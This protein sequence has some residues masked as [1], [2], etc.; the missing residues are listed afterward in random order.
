MNTHKPDMLS[1]EE[2]LERI[3]SH[4][5]VLE[6]EERPILSALG[7][8]LAEDV[9]STFAIP[10]WANSAMDGY[11][12]R[13]EDV[14]DAGPARPLVLKVIGQVAA[15]QLPRK[16]VDPGTAIRIMTGAPIPAGADTVV[17]FE[18][19][20]EVQRK[21]SGADLSRI[22]IL[23]AGKNGGNVRPAGEDITLGEKVLAQGTVLRPPEIGVLASLGKATVRVVRRPVVAILATGDELLYPGKPPR[24][25]KIYDGNSFS[26]AA[27]V[28]RYGGVAKVLGIARDNLE[29]LVA[30]VKRGLEADLLITSAGVSKGDYDIVKEVLASHGDVDFWSVRMKPAKPLAFGVLY[31]ESDKRVPLMGLPGNPVSA[32]VALEVLGRPAIFKLLGRSAQ[33]TPTIEAILE[34][35]I[36]NPDNRRVYARVAID[37]RGG[38][39]YAHLTG[40]QGSNVLTS[41]AKAQGL[42]ICPENTPKLSPG[43]K[44]RVLMLYWPE[45]LPQTPY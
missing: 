27:T 34:D 5:H 24:P 32:L 29:S 9:T 20:D 16:R 38:L 37:K 35:S 7:Q 39:Y 10:P 4:V 18:E 43:Q 6:P 26:I 21:A 2:A 8:V 30:K 1:V 42:A 23:K 33:A 12:L 28:Q 14:R 45:E 25:G 22:A 36:E 41:M 11:A 31:G 44:V 19:T 3:L 13:W 15:G 17:P 40:P